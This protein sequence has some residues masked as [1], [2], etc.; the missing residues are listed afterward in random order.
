VLYPTWQSFFP[1]RE[2]RL[3]HFLYLLF[4]ATTFPPLPFFRRSSSSVR[5][6]TS[7]TLTSHRFLK[8]YLHIVFPIVYFLLQQKRQSILMCFP[9]QT[10]T[11]FITYPD[12]LIPSPNSNFNFVMAI[13]DFSPNCKFHLTFTLISHM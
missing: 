9:S 13:T 8:A 4:F 6:I 12:D 5:Q 2:Y 10:I 11:V 3:H 7:A 1:P